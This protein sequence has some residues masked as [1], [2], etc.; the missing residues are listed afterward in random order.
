M[1]QIR[2]FE[3][4]EA[5]FDDI[6]KNESN[7]LKLS[8]SVIAK[9][10]MEGGIVHI[11]GCGHSHILGEEMYYRAGGLVP[12]HPI[13][14][15]GLML[16][17]GAAKSSD[18]EKFEGYGTIIAK[19]QD[20]RE[21]DI[22]IVISNSGRNPVPIEMAICAKEKGAKIIVLTSMAYTNSQPSRHSSGKHL[23]E[24]G[25]IVINNH[26]APGDAVLKVDG[27][28]ESFAPASTVIG[29]TILNAIF[30]S[31]VEIMH[32]NGYEPPIFIS[33]NIDGADEHNERLIERYKDRIKF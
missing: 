6:E 31:A 26:I 22:V 18:L 4:I 28:P 5:I 17:E 11:F 13:L 23:Y 1:Q 15:T 3:A 14:D 24:F 8:A 2:Y 33:G 32:E 20:I 29:A 19:Y 12:V 25:D 27:I 7:N 9:C 30:A 10:I 16:H 21:G